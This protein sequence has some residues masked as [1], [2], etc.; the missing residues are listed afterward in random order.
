MISLLTCLDLLR[1]MGLLMPT[2]IWTRLSGFGILTLSMRN[3]HTSIVFSS[4]CSC[5][6]R[7]LGGLVAVSFAAEAFGRSAGLGIG[8]SIMTNDL[9]EREN[10]DIYW[11]WEDQTATNLLSFSF[12]RSFSFKAANGSNLLWDFGDARQEI[13]CASAIEVQVHLL[14]AIPATFAT[15]ATALYSVL[16]RSKIEYRPWQYVVCIILLQNRVWFHK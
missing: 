13:D 14:A 16:V 6:I 15:S 10:T 2:S 5:G 12:C 7:S 1:C 4:I 3:A 9:F 11:L 8:C